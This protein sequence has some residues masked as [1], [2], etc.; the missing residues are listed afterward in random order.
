[1]TRYVFFFPL[2]SHRDAE[3]KIRFILC[4]NEQEKSYQEVMEG[5]LDGKTVDTCGKDSVS[6]TMREHKEIAT[7]AG[8][9]GTPAFWVNGK[10]VQGANIPALEALLNQKRSKR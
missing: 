10:S 3:Q 5:K 2:P 7:K 9:N 4:S 6:A 1:M 8:I